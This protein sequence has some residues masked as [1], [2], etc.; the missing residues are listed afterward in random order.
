MKRILSALFVI[1]I[2]IS[3]CEKDKKLSP[4]NT[5][6]VPKPVQGPTITGLSPSV[7]TAGATAI[8]TGTNLRDAGT[9]G[10]VMF[11]GVSAVIQSFSSTEIKVI[12]PVTTTGNISIATNSGVI[13]GPTFTYTDPAL[14]SRVT[15]NSG[16]AGT[17]VTLSGLHFGV[18]LP[19]VQ[20]MFN[21]VPAIVQSVTETEIKVITP[22]CTSGYVTVLKDGLSV[23][24]GMFSYITPTNVPYTG[25]NVNLSTQ[26]LVDEFVVQNMGKQ[27]Q[28]SG[29]LTISGKDI[30]S[31][32]GLANIN[33][34][35]NM[36][37]IRSCPLLTDV[38]F[39]NSVTSAGAVQLS[40]LSVTNVFMDKLAGTTG[41]IV[42]SSCPK[43]R[44]LSFKGLTNINGNVLLGGLRISVCEQ[45]TDLDFSAL[46]SCTQA[47]YISGTAAPDFS[48]FTSLQSAGSLSIVN[49]QALTSLRGLD[50]LTSLTL[51]A[52]SLAFS[53]A[54]INGLYIT[55][56]GKLNS[57]AALTNL[58]TCPVMRVTD[59]AVLNDFCPLKAQV[60]RLSALPQ[61]SYRAETRIVDVY[62]T[63]YVPALTLTA[64]STFAATQDVLNAITLCK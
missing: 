2:V 32:S 11:N 61:Y 26:A 57:L 50:L 23:N 55:G 43:L 60:K 3:A 38:S 20:V 52:L 51:P 31:L 40:D 62:M 10:K 18:S 33:S 5:V 54:T 30:T 53:S 46:R 13:S 27:L 25:G 29:S 19:D 21:G 7:V 39:L 59:N 37:I 1:I 58:E 63:K 42:V 36:L 6:P 64:N 49:N 24:A 28:I 41:S 12:V 35:S 15:P 44:S 16:P 8:I 14:V 17:I 56:N 45:L 4:G 34:V 9:P 22:T 47:I 48:K